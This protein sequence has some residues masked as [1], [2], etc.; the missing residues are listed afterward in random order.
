MGVVGGASG[1][2]GCSRRSQQL[3]TGIDAD[4]TIVGIGICQAANDIWA[5]DGRGA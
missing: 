3:P 4:A 2:K 5:H 1:A